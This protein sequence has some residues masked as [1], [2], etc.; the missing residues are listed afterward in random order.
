MFDNLDRAKQFCAEKKIEMVDF[1]M[2][3]LDGRQRHLTMPVN[4]FTEDTLEYGVGFDGS[5]YG[6]APVEKSDMVFVP[7]LTS[8]YIDNFADVPTLAMIG[9]VYVID[10]PKNRRFDQDPRNVAFHAEQYMKTLGVADEM[11]IGPEFEFHVF[12]HVSYD[13][14]PNGSM[15]KVDTSQAAW[16]T[17]AGGNNL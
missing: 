5:N 8:A 10:L 16:N 17:G 6:F 15:Y 1:M 9:D 4:R 13:I 12:D 3:D 7:D 14:K 11:R 2:I